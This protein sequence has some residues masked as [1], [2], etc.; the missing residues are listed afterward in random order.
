MCRK[1]RRAIVLD[2]A[3]RQRNNRSGFASFGYGVKALSTNE[4]IAPGMLAGRTSNYGSQLFP[5]T[6]V[7]NGFSVLYFP[8]ILG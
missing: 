1:R 2:A 3:S 7:T 6:L 5:L 8:R 4:H